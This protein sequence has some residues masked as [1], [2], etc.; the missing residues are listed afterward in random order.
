V[1]AADGVAEILPNP[2]QESFQRPP[3]RCQLREHHTPGPTRICIER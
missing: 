1:E 3:P 2:T